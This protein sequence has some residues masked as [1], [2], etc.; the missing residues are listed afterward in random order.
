MHVEG[1]DQLA[2]RVG[3]R[4]CV[5]LELLHHFDGFDRELVRTDGAG[6]AVMTS[7]TVSARR[8]MSFSNAR[9]RSPSVKMPSTRRR[10]STTV[11]MP[12][13]PR[14]I[15]RMAAATGASGCHEGQVL[16]RDVPHMGSAGGDR[17]CRRGGAGEIVGAEAP[18]IKQRDSQRIAE[19]E[20]GGRARR[21]REVVRTGLL[22]D[23][24]IEMGIRLGGERRCGAAG[25]RDDL[26][27]WRLMMG[28]IAISSALSRI[29]EGDEDVIARDHAEIAMARFCRMHE[30]GR[31]AGAGECRSDLA[32]D[33]P[34]LADAADDDAAMAVQDESECREEGAVDAVDQ[35][36]DGIRLMRRTFDLPVRALSAR[37]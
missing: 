32:R 10:L 29:R 36:G 35:G 20:G 21:R 12:I 24:C 15:S 1:A 2:V 19:G 4:Q 17:D 34:G 3:D 33:V 25:D 37:A 7:A 11:V 27:P 14:E 28:M 13:P 26:A 9:R 22:G 23:R 8:S 6:F 30:I 18:R 5:D 16:V 31:R